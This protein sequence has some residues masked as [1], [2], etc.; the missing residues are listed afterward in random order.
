MPA[1]L[2][3]LVVALAIVL[4][5]AGLSAEELPDLPAAPP[6]E[7]WCAFAQQHWLALNLVVGQPIEARLQAAVW[8]RPTRTWLA[9]L[10]TGAELADLMF[11]GGGRVQFTAASNERSDALLISPGLGVHVFPRHG[12]NWFQDAEPTTRYFLA[13]DVDVSWLHDFGSHFGFELGL[14]VGLGLRAA[15]H[16]EHP[17]STMFGPDAFPIVSVYS[18]FRF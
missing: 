2:R 8:H 12:G 4:A 1:R 15:G 16:W 13:A 6:E 17:T 18:G 14:K 7:P 5:P 10:Y 11:G 3:P 9:E